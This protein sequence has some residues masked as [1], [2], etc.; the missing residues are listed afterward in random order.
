MKLGVNQRDMLETLREHGG[1]WQEGCGWVW[2]DTYGTRRILESL[3]KHGL[4]TREEAPTNILRRGYL[5][6]LVKE[7]S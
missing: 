7:K 4:V 5:Y 1:C 3:L 2:D 6:R